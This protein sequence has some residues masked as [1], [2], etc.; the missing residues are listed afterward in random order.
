MTY[1]ISKNFLFDYGHRVH[2]QNLNTEASCSAKHKC[3][4]LHGHSGKIK[5]I[6]TADKLDD[7]GMV[8]DFNNLA[9]FKEWVDKYLDHKFLIDINDPAITMLVPGMKYM[10]QNLQNHFDA[11]TASFLHMSE[12]HSEDF[13]FALA[14]DSLIEEVQE[15][16]TFIDRVP[17]SENLAYLIYRAV[18]KGLRK[19]KL[20]GKGSEN[21]LRV[22]SVQFFETEKTSSTYIPE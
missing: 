16:F 22:K 1:E 8:T 19:L 2:S 18:D 10:E 9:W 17:T 20:I 11:D 5:L 13:I 21:N 14:K 12:I 4:Q 15:S 6:L 3:R 7:Q